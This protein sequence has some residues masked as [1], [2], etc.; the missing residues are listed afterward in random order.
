MLD[1]YC[2]H[3]LILM[4]LCSSGEWV[5]IAKQSFDSASSIKWNLFFVVS[6]LMLYP[7]NI[8]QVDD[9]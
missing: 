6:L 5:D 3:F 8:V 9:G 7:T 1:R 4:V 2:F